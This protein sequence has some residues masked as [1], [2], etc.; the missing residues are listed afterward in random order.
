M[1]SATT[2]TC[3]SLRSCAAA[4]GVCTLRRRFRQAWHPD[5]E[6]GVKADTH[7][8]LPGQG[9]LRQRE[10]RRHV[11]HR[12]PAPPETTPGP[13]PPS[14]TSNPTKLRNRPLGREPLDIGETHV[15]VRGQR[16]SARTERCT[17]SPTTRSCCLLYL[18][19]DQSSRRS[20]Q[21]RLVS[22]R[23]DLLYDDPVGR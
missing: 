22:N 1:S 6:T 15:Q 7:G 18:E 16:H 13:G 11:H 21:L 5:L 3:R 23:S 10:G 9:S 12:G 20:R 14:T 8:R 19:C 2:L 17:P 4:L